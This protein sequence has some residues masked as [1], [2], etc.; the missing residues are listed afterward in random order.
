AGQQLAAFGVVGDALVQRLA[1]ALRH[2]AVD[3]PLDDAEVDDPADV[4]AARDAGD[5]DF[6]GVGIDFDFAGLRAVRPGRRRGRLRV[7]DADPALLLPR[8]QL[9]QPDRAVGA[10]DAEAAVAEFDVAW[11]GF[12]RFGG[13]LLAP[14]DPFPGRGNDGG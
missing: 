2:A 9:A 8:R 10:A 3:L 14:E 13:E 1:D 6:A 7:G 4:V 11:R 5:A 12:E